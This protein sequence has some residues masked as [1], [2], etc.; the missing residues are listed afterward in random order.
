MNNAHRGAAAAALLSAAG[1]ACAQ[2]YS[3]SFNAISTLSPAWAFRNNS[4]PLGTNSWFAGNPNQFPP[5]ASAGYIA[6]N[7]N[8]TET[9]GTISNWMMTPA[10]VMTN[11]DTLQFW[12]RSMPGTTFPDRLQVRMSTAGTSTNVGSSA[13]SVGDFT[14]L[15]LDINPNYITG[16]YPEAW[17]QYLVTVSGLS[18]PTQGRFGFRYFVEN[19]GPGAPRSTYIG[20]DEL[21]FIVGGIQTGACCLASGACVLQTAAGCA[22]QQG[23]YRGDNSSCATANCPQPPMGACCR[24]DGTCAVI[25]LD[26]CNAIGGLFRGNG[27]TCAGAACP[28]G[29]VYTGAPVAVPD[30]TASSNCGASAWAQITVPDSFTIESAVPGYYITHPW[31][32]DLVVTLE[33]VGG[34]SVVLVDR[35]GVPQS[36]FGFDTDNY[37]A[38]STSL[39]RSNDGAFSI[40]DLPATTG[41]NNPTGNWKPESPLA[42]FAGVDSAGTWRLSVKDCAGGGLG[43]IHAFVL[44]LTAAAAPPCYANCDSS[45]TPPI[46]NVADFIC[47]QTKFAAGDSYAN[48]DASTTPPILNVSDF[49]CFQQRFAAGCS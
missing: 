15:L 10:R 7:V 24:L 20:I 8:S 12:T 39:F 30:G 36:T 38:S 16:G 37:G 35:P 32:G 41:V 43:T 19:G 11:G 45:S 26:D 42:A 14:T 3:E 49:V 18:A 23:I 29:Y 47:F 1:L 25:L 28:A 5:Q 33:K 2:S 34:P 27:T 21:D 44:T 13:T 9:G 6:A 22:G 4:V 48:C 46:L 31:Q 17:Q 40:Y